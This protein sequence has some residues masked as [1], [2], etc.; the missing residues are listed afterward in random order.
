MLR[1]GR[2]WGWPSAARDCEGFLQEKLRHGEKGAGAMLEGPGAVARYI[3]V[4]FCL[5]LYFFSFKMKQLT[6]M[7]SPCWCIGFLLFFFG[8]MASLKIL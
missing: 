2:I 6:C 4:H 1:G 7:Q 5:V 8:V 3:K